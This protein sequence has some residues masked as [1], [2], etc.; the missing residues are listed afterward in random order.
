MILCIFFFSKCLACAIVLPQRGK[1]PSWH[2][3]YMPNMGKLFVIFSVLLAV[4][5]SAATVSA[6]GVYMPDR[7]F[8]KLP[9]IPSQR[10]IL[11]YRDG[12]ETLIVE[13]SLDA[14]GQSFGW[15]IPL[16]AEPLEFRKAPPELLNV[17]S[18][19]TEPEITHESPK[20]PLV[21]FFLMS[22]FFV[23][24]IFF[25]VRLYSLV[26]VSCILLLVAALVGPKLA[27]QGAGLSHKTARIEG[28]DVKKHIDVGSYEVSV[29]KAARADD[30]N[31][32][33]EKNDFAEIPPPVASIVNE[34]IKERW[35]FIVAKLKREEGGLSIPHPLLVR[36][37]TAKPVYPMRLTA[38]AEANVFL[39]LFVVGDQTAI[40]GAGSVDHNADRP[41]V[42]FI[43][44]YSPLTQKRE[45]PRYDVFKGK[46]FHQF[47]SHPYAKE[48]LWP[49]CVV[50][51][52]AGVVSP[53]HMTED[54]TVAFRSF[55]PFRRQ[56]YSTQG[57]FAK[58]FS[59]GLY[60]WG[61]ALIIASLLVNRKGK[62][63]VL[64]RIML[65]SLCIC[66]VGIGLIYLNLAKIKVT[67]DSGF[68]SSRA[69]VAQLQILNL[70]SALD[71]YKKDT[72][73][74][75]TT[76]QGLDA[77]I[78]NPGARGW[79]G[80][81]L[82][83][84][85]PKDPWNNPYHYQSP[86][87][88]HSRDI[89]GSWYLYKYGGYNLNV[90]QKVT[91]R[92]SDIDLAKKRLEQ[93]EK[94]LDQYKKDIG[95]YPTTAQG[96]KALMLNLGVRGWNGPYIQGEQLAG[97]SEPQHYQ[98][99]SAAQHLRQYKD[100]DLCSYGEDNAPGGE[101]ESEDITSWQ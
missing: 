39:R 44:K 80:P 17:F 64:T 8:R 82:K 100:Y 5:L 23:T 2:I 92:P 38:L 56:Y 34:Y 85:I 78:S 36:F 81:Y 71:K 97:L 31:T 98:S 65:P 99:P 74:Y 7:A 76:A 66:I 77:L 84:T 1:M 26:A 28:V 87:V 42:E 11:S 14:E 33:L 96:L 69:G 45:E 18:N 37:P 90:L 32:W 12:I 13:S 27:K 40:L 50:T 29:L 55:E 19:N 10:A 72:G 16:P 41:T 52:L 61:L 89:R 46:T 75:P 68:K 60:I 35:V 4:L 95:E 48:V 93:I 20:T 88:Q 21:I 91:N 67:T 9:A 25:G 73:E 24:H 3:N 30:L 51:A 22:L 47:L 83:D 6:D 57:A 63:Y 59:Y 53:A 86:P 79:N 58:A 70:A 15:I 94:A 62:A 54:Y 49:D 43:D 101:G